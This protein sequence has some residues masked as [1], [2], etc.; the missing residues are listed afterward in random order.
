MSSASWEFWAAMLGAIDVALD[1]TSYVS[2]G[3]LRPLLS[4]EE[5]FL[6]TPSSAPEGRKQ[7]NAGASH[8]WYLL[9][10]NGSV[11]HGR[12]QRTTIQ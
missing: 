11:T 4:I 10:T 12:R 8:H 9:R 1:A 7:V 6:R 5:Y 2:T 3:H